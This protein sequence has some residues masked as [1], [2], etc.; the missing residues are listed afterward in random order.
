MLTRPT[1]V[2]FP[3]PPI[4]NPPQILPNFPF[5]KLT[6]LP[7]VTWDPDYWTSKNTSII[8]QANYVNTTLGMQTFESSS[9][10][11]G[12]GFYAMKIS[13][14]WLQG[15]ASNNLTLYIV[16]L[17]NTNP[18]AVSQSFTGPT[19]MAT[20]K[21][22]TYYHQPHAQAP[23]GAS[24]Y[25][26]IPLIVAFVIACLIGVC[27]WNRKE[28]KIALGN[29]MGRNRGYGERKTKR[30]RLGLGKNKRG[31][32]AEEQELVSEG[33]YRDAPV[34]EEVFHRRDNEDL[35]SLVGT[36]TEERTN[37]F[38]DEMRRQEAE[39]RQ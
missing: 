11:V 22:V 38:R 13:S 39:R 10:P 9:I 26:A 25:I 5:E 30:Q 33:I 35:G 4:P 15:H 20:K 23:S 8:V 12:W 27:W 18:D 29:I 32:V 19:V 17:D 21:P 2:L 7:P 16:S 24:L 37:Y 28:R 14:S 31:V 1:T 34:R 3:I 36:P 6:Q